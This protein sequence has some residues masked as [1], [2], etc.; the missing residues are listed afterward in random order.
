MNIFL[1]YIYGL[2]FKHSPP[3]VAQRQSNCLVC[4]GLELYS[5]RDGN[6]QFLHEARIRRDVG[7]ES[8]LIVSVPNIPGLYL[9]N[10]YVMKAYVHL[11]AIRS[12]VG[13]DKP[14]SLFGTG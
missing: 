10:D 8:Q 5:R 1:R 11:I 14:G 4:S 2:Y 6:F 12:S 3:A 7:A 9:R 13:E